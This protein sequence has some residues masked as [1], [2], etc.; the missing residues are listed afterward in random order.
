MTVKYKNDNKNISYTEEELRSFTKAKLKQINRE[1]QSNIE[2]VSSRR[3]DY[4]NNNK[5][6]KN[7]REY[8]NKMANYKKIIA[9]LKNQI[10]FINGL[11]IEIDEDD[12]HKREHWLWCFYM[13]VKNS[14][15]KRKFEKLVQVTDEF[16]K[17]HIEIGE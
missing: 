10:M 1:M 9:I 6:G 15:R 5:E 13:N 12:L 14:T 16:A 7:S 3:A 17:Y 2:I 4:L 11:I 8:F